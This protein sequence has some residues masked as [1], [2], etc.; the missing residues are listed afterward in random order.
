MNN[1]EF[2]LVS[3]I[4]RAN[5]MH[6]VVKFFRFFGYLSLFVNLIIGVFLTDLFFNGIYMILGYI[7][8]VFE[9]ITLSLGF[10][11][12]ALFLDDIHAIRI[13]TSYYIGHM[14]AINNQDQENQ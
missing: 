4:D 9:A 3:D 13:Q 12:I 6:W 7:I 8:T 2:H 5:Q 1:R 14:E 10:W 11:A